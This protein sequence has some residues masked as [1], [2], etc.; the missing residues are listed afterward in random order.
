MAYS[1]AFQVRKQPYLG[2][3]FH[4]G[5]PNLGPSPLSYSGRI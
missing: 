3:D 1:A 4:G 2:F 5:F